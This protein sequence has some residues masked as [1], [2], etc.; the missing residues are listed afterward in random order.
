MSTEIVISEAEK[1]ALKYSARERDFIAMAGLGTKV[2]VLR[3]NRGKWR[4]Y[5]TNFVTP[6]SPRGQQAESKEVVRDNY[7]Y[8][9]TGATRNDLVVELKQEYPNWKWE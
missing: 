4:A 3:L 8:I 1:A 7:G 5:L 6:H 2:E 9:I